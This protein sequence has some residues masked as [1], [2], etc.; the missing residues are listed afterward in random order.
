MIREIARFDAFSHDG[1]YSTT[2]CV[3]RDDATNELHY[4]TISGGYRIDR[5]GPGQYVVHDPWSPYGPEIV[6][7]RPMPVR[8]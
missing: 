8:V 7:Y 6:V 1:C 5:I 3:L 2:V 4:G